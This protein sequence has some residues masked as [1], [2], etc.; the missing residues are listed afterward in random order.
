M[1]KLKHHG[2]QII[3]K[4]KC[5]RMLAVG[6]IQPG[7]FRP[8]IRE[9]ERTGCTWEKYNSQ[10]LND[11]AQKE[12]DEEDEGMVRGGKEEEEGS[13][14]PRRKFSFHSRSIGEPES[15]EPASLGRSF[16]YTTRNPSNTAHTLTSSQV[17]LHLL[18]LRDVTV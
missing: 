2:V 13:G 10:I 9:R 16:P 18:Y 15:L 17:T 3:L 7:V 6:T 4:A 5:I 1:I 11:R 8:K 14:S 12:E